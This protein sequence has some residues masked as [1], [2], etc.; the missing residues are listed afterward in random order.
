MSSSR[1]SFSKIPSA[2]WLSE[3][4]TLENIRQ[5]K[6][7]LRE[8]GTFAFPSL[9][10]GLFSAA[11]GETPD[12]EVTGYHNVWIRDN[13][14][15]AW[16]LWDRGRDRPAAIRC[17]QSLLRFFHS[18]HERLEAIIAGAVHP[19][20][21][22]S[23]PHIRFDG[24]R[25][26]ELDEKWPHA[27]ND[28]L[29]Y[30]L[31]LSCLMLADE[32]FEA[33][34]TDWSAISLLVEYFQA[35]EVWQDEDSGHWEENRKIAASSI[36]AVAAGLE[37]L[38]RLLTSSAV[39]PHPSRSLK[40][41][42]VQTLLARCRQALQEI[43]P[44][45]CRQSEPAKQR[46]HDA[47]LLFLLYP[48]NQVQDPETEDQILSDVASH[49]TGPIGIRRYN[50][51]SYWCNDY[52]QLF[53]PELRSSDFSED[54]ANRDCL[55]RPGHEAQWCLFDPIVACIYG[56]RFQRSHRPEDLHRHLAATRRSLAQLTRP[57]DRFAP[58]RC[59]ESWFWE[60]GQWIPNDITPLLWTQANLLQALDSLEQ[61]LLLQANG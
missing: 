13:V 49:L 41:T 44:W 23:R 18:Q 30:L 11:A 58:Y 27:Q 53:T 35:I 43:L 5:I 45:E 55:L 56:R 24:P 29:G 1:D 17:V 19:S 3:A 32:A 10:N 42:E 47:A 2:D 57:E 61:S 60:Q 8:Q 12:F 4:P 9:P 33:S 21:I 15:V 54:I 25:L 39:P 14:H 16:S 37:A 28:A 31:W 34:P 7:F 50:G 6:A 38:E 52:R 36:G 40:L 26:Q 20:E 59:P 48:L 46:P 22:Q 51:D